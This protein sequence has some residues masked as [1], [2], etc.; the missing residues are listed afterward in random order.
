MTMLRADYRHVLGGS[1]GS[2]LVLMTM[3]LAAVVITRVVLCPLIKKILRKKTTRGP[4][5]VICGMAMVF[6]L[7]EPRVA[8]F[9]ELLTF[10]FF[11][12]G[13]VRAIE[14]KRDLFI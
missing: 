14:Q 12:C 9:A 11:A 3:T 5:C 7:F 6:V 10:F 13:D 1:L 8:P 4:P 2:Q